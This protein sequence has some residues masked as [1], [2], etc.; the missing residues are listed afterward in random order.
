MKTV[1]GKVVFISAPYRA[2][3]HL[4]VSRNIER[5]RAMAATI[6]A[7]GGYAICPHTN[8]AF[9]SGAC[10]ESRFMDGYLEILGRCDAIYWDVNHVSAGFVAE[11]DKA[12]AS[13]LELIEASELEETNDKG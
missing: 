10:E 4:Q 12:V 2:Q 11:L 5:A 1:T 13:G 6:W 3:T 8:T 7:G 9:M